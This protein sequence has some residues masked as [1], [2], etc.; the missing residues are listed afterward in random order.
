M[1]ILTTPEYSLTAAIVTEELMENVLTS[2]KKMLH[3][4]LAWR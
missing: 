3:A 1:H 2:D 4:D